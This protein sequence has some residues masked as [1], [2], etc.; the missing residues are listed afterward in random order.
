MTITRQEERD[1]LN[2][3]WYHRNGYPWKTWEKLRKEDPVHYIKRDDGD[4]YWAITRWQD[5]VDIE[6]NAEVFKK[7]PKLTID[8]PVP[9]G[10]P[11][12][13]NLDSPEHEKHRAYAVPMLAPPKV[14]WAKSFAPGIIKETFDW[15]MERNG[16]VIDFQEDVANMVPTAV[17]CTFLGIPRNMWRQV[18][19]WTTIVM[20]S[21]DPGVRK[22]L[23][24][25]EVTMKTSMEMAQYFMGTFEDRK[26]NPR[27]NDLP[28]ALVNARVDGKPL[29]L[30]QLAGWA[31]LLMLGGHD[32]TQNMYG[33]TVHTL[34]QH[35]DQL[36]KLKANP[37]L[38]PNA[39]EELMRYIS[40][41]VHFVRTP[42][43]D[44]EL[45]GKKIKAGDYVTLFYPS[46]NRDEEVFPDPD[47]LDLERPIGRRRHQSFG[48]GPHVCIGMHLARIELKLLIEAF[49]ERVESIECAGE[50]VRVYCTPTGGY[51]HFP[52]RM[53]VRPQA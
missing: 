20:N 52:V 10:L 37:A 39:I 22:G 51:N 13:V 41:P 35:P 43:R 25:E 4:S 46:A 45:R 15:A 23:S 34:M 28:T 26:K 2:P 6:A 42:D 40:I 9:S 3:A 8:Y 53:K 29:P 24:Q 1:L 27:E 32:T 21:N 44:V 17:I 12:I 11:L 50:P 38:L 7:R 48:S 18:I 31:V 36:A 33:M 47:K 14:E 30:E 49:L 5:V 16:Q 19:D